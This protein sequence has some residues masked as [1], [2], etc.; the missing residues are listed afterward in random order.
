[1][2]CLIIVD[3]K[4]YAENLLKNGFS[5]FMSYRDLLILAKYYR[6]TG[7]EYKEIEI[8]LEDFCLRYNPLY[9]KVKNRWR[10][11]KAVNGAKKNNLRLPFSIVITENEI[12]R[13]L[14]I[15]NRKYERVLFAILVLAKYYK[16]SIGKNKENQKPEKIGYYLSFDFED[17]ALAAKVNFTQKKMIECFHKLYLAGYYKLTKYGSMMIDYA[18]DSSTPMIEVTDIND[19]SSFLPYLCTECGKIITRTGNRKIMCDECYAEKKKSR[20]YCV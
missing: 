17:I 10:I 13:I 12:K 3:E 16:F 6:W 2:K 7:L 19:I 1:M 20:E 15:K 5:K 11:V 4:T 14:S 9:N 8:K 18:D